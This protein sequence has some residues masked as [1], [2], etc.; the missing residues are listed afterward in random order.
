ME[1]K[2]D[3][4]RLNAE[5]HNLNGWQKSQNGALLRF[6]QKVDSVNRKVDNL[7]KWILGVLATIVA[8]IFINLAK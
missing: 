6:D 3:V 2:E 7:Q 8:S 1:L 5:V 4:A